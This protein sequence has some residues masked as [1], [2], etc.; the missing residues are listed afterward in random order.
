MN[1]WDLKA[2]PPKFFEKSQRSPRKI[3]G[4]VRGAG[5]NQQDGMTVLD[6]AGGAERSVGSEASSGAGALWSDAAAG[7]ESGGSSKQRSLDERLG[8]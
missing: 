6:G 5:A 4:R 7:A 2:S 3:F 1:V 8:P